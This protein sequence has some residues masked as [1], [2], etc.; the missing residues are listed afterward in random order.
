[1]SNWEEMILGDYIDLITGYAFSSDLFNDSIGMPLIRIRDFES[2]N[3]ITY[4]SGE[5]DGK[6]I[7]N[8]GDK[9]ISMDGEFNIIEWKGPCSLLNQRVCKIQSNNNEKMDIQFLMYR[10]VRE[11][12]NIEARTP[13]TTVKHLSLKD[14]QFLKLSI[15]P[16][17]EQQKIA[18][19]LSSVDA[20]IEKTEQVIAKTE[21]LKKGLMQQLLTKGIGHTEFKKTEFGEIPIKWS[22]EN[23][24]NVLTLLKDGT[25]NPPKAQDKGIP[26]LS[27]ENI[28]NHRVNFGIQEKFI[29]LEDYN[30]MHKKYEI[31]TNDILLTIV[32]TIGRTAIVDKGCKFTVQRSVAI[33]RANESILVSKFLEYLLNTDMIRKQLKLRSNASAQAGI[34]LGELGKVRLLIPSIEEQ[35]SIIKILEN[36]DEKLKCEEKGL[37]KLELMKRGLMQQLL[38]GQ[39]RV[40]ID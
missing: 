24:G 33:L 8:P 14:L 23:L 30:N 38:T 4:Y 37:E 11:L 32:G 12:K 5:Y 17:K 13:A 1:M 21:E 6:Y 10:L 26:M 36:I 20:A 28:F 27:A 22:I 25:H 35:I 3:P 9:L 16:L 7:V 29:S 39:V 15:P 18:E 40:K 2:Q 34:Y 31:E 19:I